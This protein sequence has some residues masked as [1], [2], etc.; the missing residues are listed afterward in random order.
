MIFDSF[1]NSLYKSVC[2]RI[3]LTLVDPGDIWYGFNDVKNV[4]L[5]HAHFDH[6]YGL[7]KVADFSTEFKVYTNEAG[8]EMLFNPKLNMSKY[9]E[10]PFE[11]KFYDKVIVVNDGDLI[12]IGNGKMAKALFTPGHN[13]SCVTWIVEDLLFTGDS[14]IPGIKTVTN[15]P[16]GNRNLCAASEDLIKTLANGRRICP[17]HQI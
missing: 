2:Y 14:F 9:H 12:D 4:F 1:V 17:G 8:K 6:I 7:N 10:H 15:L 5:T 3:G 13:P 11:F 16:G